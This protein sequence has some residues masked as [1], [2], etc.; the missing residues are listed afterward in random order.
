[1]ST[2]IVANRRRRRR[3]ALLILPALFA[4]VLLF[5]GYIRITYNILFRGPFIAH[6]FSEHLHVS[7]A[8]DDFDITFNSYPTTPSNTL[9]TSLP[10]PP[11]MHQIL[12]GSPKTNE[13]VTIARKA[14]VRMHPGYEFKLWTDDNAAD[15][16]A[17][18]Y[19][20]LFDM[21]S[22]YRFTIQKADS[23]RYMVLYAYG[24][25][26][27]DLDLECRR[28]LDPL[29]QFEF[30]APAATPMG[31]SNGFLMVAPKHPFMKFTL[32]NL[33]SYNI[34]WFGLPYATVMFSTG[35]HFLSTMQSIFPQRDSLR[36]LW[37]PNNL[38]R[39]SGA[40]TTPIFRHLGM[41]SWHAADGGVIISLFK[42][43]IPPDHTHNWTGGLASNT[44]IKT[45]TIDE[46][47]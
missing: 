4:I 25:V 13:N 6:A 42:P 10:V 21:W 40:V 45:E 30:V 17:K 39:L 23:L 36:V 43:E 8:R 34:N 47:E 1:M 28:P 16:V 31:I 29:R 46:L 9:N 5:H 35:C 26:F 33:R 18:E 24:G 44:D 20:H 41:S 32:E 2:I 37:G 38:H 12:L 3:K 7:K 27:L 15:F 19:P 14:C 11:I 22:S